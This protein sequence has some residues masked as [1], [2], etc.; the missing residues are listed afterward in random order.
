MYFWQVIDWYAYGITPILVGLLE[1]IAFAFCYGVRRISANLK[2][3][4]GRAPGLYWIICWLFCSPLTLLVHSHRFV[5]NYLLD[6][7][8]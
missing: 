6:Y 2:L 3:M 7:A 8:L 5:S 4:T 1:C